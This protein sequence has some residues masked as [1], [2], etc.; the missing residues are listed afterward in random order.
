[1]LYSIPDQT[2]DD[3]TNDSRGYSWM[4]EKTFT[5]K[6]LPL[7]QS[8]LEQGKKLF[9]LDGGGNLVNMMDAMT[10]FMEAA[11]K[12]NKQLALLIFTTCGQTP[13]IS[14]FVDHKIANS[15]RPR[16]IFHDEE[17]FWFVTR[18]AKFET[19]IHHD[20]FI[21]IKANPRVNKLLEKYLVLIR[22]LEQSFASTIWGAEEAQLYQ[23]Y[24]CMDM[25]E[26]LV[27]ATFSKM[28][29]NFTGSF[30]LIPIG[31]RDYRHLMVQVARTY[32][33]SEN[34]VDEHEEDVLAGQHGHGLATSRR[35]YAPELGHLP[36]MSSDLLLRYGRISEA[37]W[38]VVGFRPNY[39]PLLPLQ[40][41]NKFI[42]S[43]QYPAG[44]PNQPPAILPSALDIGHLCSTLIAEIRRSEACTKE[45]MGH[46]FS[47]GFM[48]A[49]RQNS[50]TNATIISESVE[51]IQ[52]QI[53]KHIDSLLSK[54]FNPLPGSSREPPEIS[55]KFWEQ[56]SF[57]QPDSPQGADEI[58]SSPEVTPPIAI[59][60]HQAPT[61]SQ[62]TPTLTQQTPTLSQQ[63]PTLSQQVPT[64]SQQAPTLSQQTPILSQQAQSFV[65]F[66]ELFPT[67]GFKSPQQQQLV[68]EAIQNQHS[69]IGILPTGGGK[70]L[71]YLLPSLQETR[72][73]IVISPNK[74]LLA[75]QVSKAQKMGIHCC[76]WIANT[77]LEPSQSKVVFM[78][79][80]TV[81]SAAFHSFW[82][83][84]GRNV[85]RIVLDE[86][87]QALTCLGFRTQF[88]KLGKL[89]A[90]KTQRIFLTATL[91][92]RLEEPFIDAMNLP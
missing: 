81:I 17:G 28:L 47:T 31:P 4:Y 89:A 85:A 49:L 48:E 90:Y 83:D 51:K 76:Q 8:L 46:I 6:P 71:I 14:E 57:S 56:K 67:A 9:D 69:C 86:C 25:G 39:P 64:L 3:W 7:L 74:A 10:A 54:G 41:R 5:Q 91:P 61:L 52:T 30:S 66:Q 73:T 35:C 33:G 22:P 38:E 88:G 77:P 26:R 80:E 53:T 2:P 13:R 16:T 12:I 84:H 42:P 59:L 58:D 18:R 72:I 62:Q 23:E 27:E 87:H 44:T 70:S 63:V 60:S 21:P 78:A 34:E 68:E 79:M 11:A 45:N 20:V 50:T 55:N 15:T 1:M 37:W 75:D 19:L 29:A 24:F 65:I 92:K 82:T 36:C 40:V 43:Y 32:L